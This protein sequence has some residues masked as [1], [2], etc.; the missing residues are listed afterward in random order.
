MLEYG[1]LLWL[2]IMFMHFIILFLERAPGHG[3]KKVN[4]A[5]W[6]LYLFCAMS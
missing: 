6:T 3:S 5:V 2:L 1:R 4:A